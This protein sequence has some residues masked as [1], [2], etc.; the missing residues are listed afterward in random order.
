MR[1]QAT[2]MGAIEPSSSKDKRRRSLSEATVQ[3]IQFELMRRAS[4]NAFDGSRVIASLRR[5][6]DLWEAVLMDNRP[7]WQKDRYQL[8]PGWLIKLRDLGGDCW[9]VD[10]LF[11]LAP[12]T[13]S[14]KKLAEAIK[15]EDWGGMTKVYG[16]ENRAEIERTL[17]SG[18][19][20]RA[21]VTVWWDCRKAERCRRAKHCPLMVP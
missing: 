8:P 5:H 13:E 10:T 9:N 3:E 15:E 4:F 11:I 7:Y 2:A 12:N 1:L 6:A 18:P 16:D 17:G 21:I 20:Q 14:A 19:D